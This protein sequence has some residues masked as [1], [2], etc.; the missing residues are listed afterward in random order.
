V[1][2]IHNLSD[3]KK[4]ANDIAPAKRYYLQNFRPEKTW[5]KNF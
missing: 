4:M 2:T 5:I 3:I 1:P